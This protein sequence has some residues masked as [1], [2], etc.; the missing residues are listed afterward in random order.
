MLL[1]GKTGRSGGATNGTVLPTGHFSEKRHTFRGQYSSSLVFTKMTGISLNYFLHVLCSL[2]RYAVYFPKLPVERT[3][4]FDSP[5]EQLFFFSYKWKALENC[6]VPQFG[7]NF[8][9]ARAEI[10]AV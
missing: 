8:S 3:V 6:I 9:I 4:P 10:A 7:G 1:N 5:T 2:M